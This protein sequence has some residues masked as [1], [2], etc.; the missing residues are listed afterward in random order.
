MLIRLILQVEEMEKET[1]NVIAKY[2]EI[3][4]KL[5][6]VAKEKTTLETKSSKLSTKLGGV[7]RELQVSI[8]TTTECGRF[9]DSFMPLPIAILMSFI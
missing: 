2:S 7:L 8:L 5:T 4:D 1:R 3:E 9:R 6:S